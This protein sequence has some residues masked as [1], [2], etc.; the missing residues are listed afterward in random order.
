MNTFRVFV[1]N[2]ESKPSSARRTQP[3]EKSMSLKLIRAVLFALLTTL[4][5]FGSNASAES[6]HGFVRDAYYIGKGGKVVS[7]KDF[8][9]NPQKYTRSDVV[10]LALREHFSR[11]V[12]KPLGDVEFRALLASDD[13]RL[14][15]CVEDKIST[16]GV[17][18]K[19]NIAWHKRNCYKDERLIEA[20]VPG[21]WM[22]VASQGCYNPVEGVRPTPPK[23]VV[24]APVDGVCGPAAGEYSATATA[25]RG[26]LCAVGVATSFVTLP[27]PGHTATYS[28]F[29]QNGGKR[30]TCPIKVLA[31]A[32]PA[33]I[34]Q[35]ETVVTGATTVVPGSS[36]YVGGINV[37]NCGGSVL[38]PGVAWNNPSSTI[39]SKRYERRL[40]NPGNRN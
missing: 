35:Y 15:P 38:V 34:P 5:G 23:P 24:A 13:V 28:C 8:A 16:A 12:G 18:D 11:V 9:A 27:R 14:V 32:P 1:D 37:E 39:S 20:K 2:L 40:V 17:T 3:K 4:L 26:Q 29:E 19:G 21:G 31:E 33:P 25:L 36:G 6:Y 30:A 7:P 10:Y 22:V